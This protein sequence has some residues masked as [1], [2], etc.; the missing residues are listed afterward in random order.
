[1]M[2]ESDNR[3]VLA[4]GEEG[5]YRLQVVNSVHGPDTERLLIRA[6]LKP[7]MQVADI[8]C[9]IGTISLRIAEHVGPEGEVTGVDISPEQIAQARREA[10]DRGQANVR[11]RVASAT[12]TGLSRDAFDLVFCRFVLMHL[13]RPGDAIREMRALLR[14]GGILVCEDGDFT[15]PFCEPPSAAFERC[16]ELYRAIGE[17]RGL[18]FRLGP[19]L[20]RL[21]LDAGF[22]SPEVALA[23]PVFLRGDA[24]RL[25]EWTL[26]ESAPALVEAGLAT[27]EEIDRIAAE[28][29]AIAEDETTLFGMAQMTQVWARRLS[30]ER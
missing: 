10:Q 26:V 4:T 20:Y 3:Y 13:A 15:R 18:D 23:Q 29:K 22:E 28:L 17:R 16:F 24:K 7:G 11:F 2:A 21:F 25:P 8:G 9:G 6:G 14:P 30:V 27:R 5:A 12:D 1:M 19:R